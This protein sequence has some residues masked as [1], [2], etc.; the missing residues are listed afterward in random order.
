MAGAT[1]PRCPPA[2][3]AGALGALGGLRRLD[4]AIAPPQTYLGP[5]GPMGL[6][7]YVGLFD[8]AELRDGDVVWVS[9]AAGAVGSLVAQFAKLRGH[10]VIGSAGSDE[11]VAVLLGELGLDAAFDYREGAIEDQ[12]RAA[13]PEGIDV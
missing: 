1:K 7:A 6:T 8:V 9:A 10:V 2:P 3:G 4:T 5:L 12:L 13:A 11:K